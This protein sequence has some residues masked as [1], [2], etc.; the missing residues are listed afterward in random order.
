MKILI[1]GSGDTGTYL[2]KM[3]ANE[4]QDVVLMSDRSEY[5]KTIDSTYNLLTFDGDPCSPSDL[6]KV[7]VGNAKMFI[8]VTPY[9]TR[10]MVACQLA[11]HLG[12]GSTIARVEDI[13]LTGPDIAGAFAVAGIDAMVY[14]EALVAKDIKDYINHNWMVSRHE[15]HNGQLVFAGIR[16]TDSSPLS[17]VCLRDM[18]PDRQFHISAIRRQRKTIIPDGSDSLLPGD[19]A[20]CTCAAADEDAVRRAAGLNG[21]P[22]RHI[23]ITGNSNLVALLIERL[24]GLGISISLIS[25]NEE[26]CAK[27]AGRF[28]G[29][30]VSNTIP[31]DV[32]TLHDEGIRNCDLFLAMED[33]ASESIIGAITA[34]EM[35]A[36]HTVAQIEDIHY[37]AEA[38]RLGIDKVVNK[39]LIT[40]AV[41]LRS[42]MGRQ[43]H[44]RTMISLDNAEV[45]ELE[46]APGSAIT[47]ANVSQLP[48]PAEMTFGALVHEG[49]STIITGNTHIEAG[50]L[51]LVVFR[52]GTLDK[53]VKLFRPKKIL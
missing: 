51:V 45:A 37:I 2:A 14:P 1:A 49:K 24:N 50:D 18:G 30:S 19:I 26:F 36:R 12:A 9:G 35:G 48:I 52:P 3:L 23:I 20:Y 16:I 53:V 25:S 29:V 11:R 5:L 21:D 22:I 4:K 31:G 32:Q 47:K 40:S 34:K 33:T 13:D 15:L 10:N 8:A 41:I 27:I 42:I 43:L 6:R 7:G 28:P 38:E 39:K 46:V 17:G 44:V